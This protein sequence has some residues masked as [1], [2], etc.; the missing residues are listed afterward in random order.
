MKQD[1]NIGEQM[2]PSASGS[3]SSQNL[4][5]SKPAEQL[6]K[7]IPSQFISAKAAAED[8][9]KQTKKMSVMPY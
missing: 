6:N 2:D 8:Q 1:Y 3:T 4:M 9:P 7:K 5:V